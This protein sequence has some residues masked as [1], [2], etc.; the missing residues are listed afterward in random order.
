MW[1]KNNRNQDV[2][3][4]LHGPC[5]IKLTVDNFQ[6]RKKGYLWSVVYSNEEF[7]EEF[8]T[9]FGQESSVFE[10]KVLAEAVGNAIL[11]CCR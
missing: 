1:V 3:V 10:A 2:T 7:K 5:K 6:T 8:S 9:S 4:L 11:D